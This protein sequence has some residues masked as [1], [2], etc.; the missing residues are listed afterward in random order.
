LYGWDICSA[1][2]RILFNDKYCHNVVIYNT[3]SSLTC[4]LYN[5]YTSVTTDF[6]PDN[7]KQKTKDNSAKF[8]QMINE[9]AI[10]IDQKGVSD[11]IKRITGWYKCVNLNNF[12]LIGSWIKTV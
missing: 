2:S 10:L 7:Q 12:W 4:V 1:N 9:T 3:I 11:C 5:N 6:P 8:M